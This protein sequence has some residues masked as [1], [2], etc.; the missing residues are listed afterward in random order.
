MNLKSRL[1]TIE[2]IN[3]SGGATLSGTL[4]T[5]STNAISGLTLDDLEVLDSNNQSH[6]IS[7][8]MPV[9]VTKWRSSSLSGSLP[10]NI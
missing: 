9:D 2:W 6:E 4:T 5:S 7:S 1:D 8:N 3:V 10:S